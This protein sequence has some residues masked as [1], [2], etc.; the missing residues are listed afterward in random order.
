MADHAVDPRLADRLARQLAANDLAVVVEAS[1]GALVLSGVVPT[2]E[3]RQAVLDI[4]STA[5]PDARV[6]DQLD[7]ESV[8]PADIDRFA[9]G[10]PST[11]P[12]RSRIEIRERDEEL[13]PDF[14]D[15]PI[16]RDPVAASG[17]SSSE[18]EDLVESGDEVYS[19][20]D[21]PV[22]STDQHGRPK[23]LGGFGENDEVTVERSAL[24]GQ[25]GDEALA[26]AV[27]QE[28]SE[29]AATADLLIVV[30]VRNGIAHLRGKVADLEDAENAEAVAARVPG[31][32]EVVEELEVAN[33]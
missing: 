17:P 33:V 28:L 15:Q 7:V 20:P 27:R 14:S 2:E 13:D 8:L 21:D 16:L 23:V 6:D 12:P 4:I 10:E 9:S 30:A 1:E 3:A 32:R 29:D 22:L 18:A 31:V 5:A 26:D 24:D 25:P 11:E 19:P